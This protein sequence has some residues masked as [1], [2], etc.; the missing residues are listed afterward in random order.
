[1]SFHS[2][3]A[4][5]DSYSALTCGPAAISYGLPFSSWVTQIGPADRCVLEGATKVS[6]TWDSCV[7]SREKSLLK[8]LAPF[9]GSPEFVWQLVQSFA[10][11]CCGTEHKGC[12]LLPAVTLRDHRQVPLPPGAPF[13]SLRTANCCVDEGLTMWALYCHLAAAEHAARQETC[14]RCFSSMEKPLWS[15]SPFL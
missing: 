9:H 12:V 3:R 14:K 11:S 2:P 6:K 4:S 8:K 7:Q 13:P 15:R 1:M 5:P 10:S